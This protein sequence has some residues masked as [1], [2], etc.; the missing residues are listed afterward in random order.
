MKVNN[1]QI[2]ALLGKRMEGP[3]VRESGPDRTPRR[4][5]R[6]PAKGEAEAS[7]LVVRFSR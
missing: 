6:E 3:P 5:Q 2:Y 4:T 7:P 1:D